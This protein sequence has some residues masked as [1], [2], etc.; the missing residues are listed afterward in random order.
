MWQPNL[1]TLY[2]T[3]ASASSGVLLNSLNKHMPAIV[4]SFWN[5]YESN[6]SHPY[7]TS[8]RV[9]EYIW[10]LHYKIICLFNIFLFL[11]QRSMTRK[12]N[13]T[14]CDVVNTASV[15]TSRLIRWCRIVDIEH[16]LFNQLK[17]TQKPERPGFSISKVCIMNFGFKVK[18]TT[19]WV[20]IFWRISMGGP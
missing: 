2:K 5:L 12:N 8:E 4:A 18:Q 7:Y 19:A 14:F 20:D 16:E 9:M 3:A 10:N 6:F 13:R 11:A 17:M 1:S 15:I